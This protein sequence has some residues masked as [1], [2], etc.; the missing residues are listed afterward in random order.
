MNTNDNKEFTL[1]FGIDFVIKQDLANRPDFQSWKA[2][3]NSYDITCPFC[4]TKRKMNINTSKNVAKC[5]KCGC[6]SGYNTITLHAALTGLDNKE[7]YKDLMNRWNGLGSDVKVQYQN[8]STAQP[9]GN[10]PAAIEIRDKVYRRLLSKLTLSEKHHEDLLR[11]GLNEDQITS[12]MYKTVPAIGLH[13]LAYEA[14]YDSGAI[15]D[16]STHKYW[17]IPGFVD[18][19]DPNKISLRGRK[20]GYFVPVLNK[21][22]LIS[23]MQIRYDNLPENASDKEKELYKK[24]SW[25][26]SSEKDSG[27]GVTGCENIH[28]AGDW[29]SNVETINL[30]EGVLKADIASALSGK[31]FLGLVG[32]N[33]IRQL[34]ETLEKMM[35]LGTSNVNLYVDMD[36]RYKKEVAQALISIRREINSAGHHNYLVIEKNLESLRLKAY[37][38]PHHHQ[39]PENFH[40]SVKLF[41][42]EALPEDILVFI[43]KTLIPKEQYV[44]SSHEIEF[45]F[46]YMSMLRNTSHE[47]RIIDSTKGFEDYSS[48]SIGE[49][50][51]LLSKSQFAIL[52]FLKE[53]LTYKEMNW[54]EKYKG[55]DDYYLYLRSIQKISHN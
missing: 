21:D 2:P 26:S 12:G 24:Y 9:A 45:N 43:G 42:D 15:K 6:G 14:V 51:D 30:T 44:V 50:K 31:P 36:Y 4:N 52:K 38:Y 7:S 37:E 3:G 32:V 49:R 46:E 17:G 47:L 39:N 53:G 35:S 34:K 33:N 13:S 8:S 18:I 19:K 25:Y 29:K 20:N 1:P 27:C 54:N 40:K 55:I 48:L 16:L 41:C 10:E 22:G 11:R 5:N 23:G 28:F